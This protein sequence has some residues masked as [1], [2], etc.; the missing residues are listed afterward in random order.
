MAQTVDRTFQIHTDTSGHPSY[1][2]TNFQNGP[3]VTMTAD[4]EYKTIVPEGINTAIFQTS[5]GVDVFI[6]QDD[7]TGTLT[8]PGSSFT[9]S[10]AELNKPGVRGVVPG[11]TLHFR[12]PVTCYLKVNYYNDGSSNG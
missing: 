2:L 1:L 3:I 5:K 8:L 11:M 6:L 12:A 7:G 4:T 9:L 10:N